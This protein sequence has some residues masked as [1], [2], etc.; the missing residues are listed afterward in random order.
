MARAVWRDSLGWDEL[1]GSRGRRGSDAETGSLFSSVDLEAR[2]PKD[3]PLR[4]IRRLVDAAL[5]D[6]SPAFERLSAPLGRPSIPP[7]RLVRAL[8]L[9]LQAFYSVR[10][11]R[12]LMEQRGD[13][14]LFRWFV[15]SMAA[16]RGIPARS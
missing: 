11:A 5:I 15:R 12:Q 3:H 8:L 16:R 7:E 10:S 14:L 1:G 2:V 9:L 6:L 4:P 13:S